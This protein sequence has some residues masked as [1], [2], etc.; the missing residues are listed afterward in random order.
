LEE[1]LVALLG[2]VLAVPSE[3]LLGVALALLLA[4]L[5]EGQS[6][7]VLVERLEALLAVAS[8]GRLGALSAE[9]LAVV[10]GVVWV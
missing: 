3:V 2:E 10:S 7:E 9:Q 4:A 1:V 6:A 8:G 5:W